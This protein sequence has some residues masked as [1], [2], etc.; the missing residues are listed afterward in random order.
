VKKFHAVY[1]RRMVD[2]EINRMGKNWKTVK[3]LS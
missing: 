2:E 3:E 1:G